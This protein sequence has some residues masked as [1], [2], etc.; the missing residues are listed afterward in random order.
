M[1]CVHKSVM[2]VAEHYFEKL[3]SLQKKYLNRQGGEAGQIFS[4]CKMFI[5]SYILCNS[6]RWSVGISI[7]SDL[8]YTLECIFLIMCVCLCFCER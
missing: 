2:Q 4:L 3:C 7:N 8:T 6:E 1:I 5:S